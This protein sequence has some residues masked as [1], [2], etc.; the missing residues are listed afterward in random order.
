LQSAQ[1]VD[2]LRSFN[3]L[4]QIMDN[5]LGREERVALSKAL[6]VLD[7]VRSI[8]A[9]MPITAARCFLTVAALDNPSVGDVERA[10][11]FSRSNASRLWNYLGKR[12]RGGK[13]GQD[14]VDEHRDPLDNRK[15]ILRLTPRGEL[16]VTQLRNILRTT[17]D[18]A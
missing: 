17:R 8:D 1:I 4:T 18:G 14:L 6:Q 2:I 16:V 11:G 5:S 12:A 13:P 3:F 7:L 10:G 9:D 15:K